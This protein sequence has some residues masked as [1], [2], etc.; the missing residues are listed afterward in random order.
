MLCK[1]IHLYCGCDNTVPLS[2]TTEY[3]TDFRDHVESDFNCTIT[4]MKMMLISVAM[5]L[6]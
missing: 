1:V 4:A 3:S 6:F 2:T 5:K